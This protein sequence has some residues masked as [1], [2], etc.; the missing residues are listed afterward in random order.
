MSCLRDALLVPPLSCWFK[1]WR[2]LFLQSCQLGGF[3]PFSK[4]V[5]QFHYPRSYPQQHGPM[6]SASQAGRAC[7]GSKAL[8]DFPGF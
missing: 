8:P 4:D 3:T 7:P 2:L 5:E 1:R 6:R